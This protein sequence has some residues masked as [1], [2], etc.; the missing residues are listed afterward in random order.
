MGWVLVRVILTSID[1]GSKIMVTALKQGSAV[2]QSFLTKAS[3][4]IDY[5]VEIRV[6]KPKHRLGTGLGEG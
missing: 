5:V 6:R 4:A 3:E 2:L 1:S